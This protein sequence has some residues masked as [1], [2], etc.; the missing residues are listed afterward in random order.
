MDVAEQLPK[1]RNM[2]LRLL[3]KLD[4][5]EAVTTAVL[6]YGDASWGCGIDLLV[7]VEPL[8]LLVGRRAMGM[9]G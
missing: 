5:P 1:R 9:G 3:Q 4:C 6:S 7:A 8:P 2:A